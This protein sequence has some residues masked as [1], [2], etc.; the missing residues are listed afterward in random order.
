MKTRT[1]VGV[2]LVGL[3]AVAGTVA[4]ISL[5]GG[6]GEEGPTTIEVTRGS[7]A[8]KALAIGNIEPD[9]EISVK[10]Q[11]SGVVRELFVEDGDFVTAGEPLLEVQPNPTPIELADSKRQVQLRQ[12][13]LDNMERDLA[14][15]RELRGRDF[16]TQ[17]E[18]EQAER[19]YERARVQVQMATERVALLETGR[20]R[21]ANRDI[22]G[23]V[24]SPIDGFV[25]ETRVETGDPVVPL[26]AFQEGT[27]LIT[28]AAMDN[29][30]FRGT[31]D[32]IDV[33]KLREGM[34]ADVKVGA[35]PDAKVTGSV[36]AISLKARTEDNATVF[37]IEVTLTDVGETVLRA[38]YSANV[39]VII[40][41]TGRCPGHP[42]ASDPL[43]GRR[44]AGHGAAPRW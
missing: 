24:R 44:A 26:S 22:E 27:V 6:N 25:L 4:T 20:V 32:E 9:V 29:L 41:S 1:K 2:G 30:I 35:L 19:E 13:D 23:V 11:L 12:I 7:I 37:P 21:I 3:V 40:R 43:R 18:L 28:M 14:R 34:P 31:V 8:Q 17:E 42:R 16:I 5:R 39:D 33:G 38:G 15:K 36:H 10:S